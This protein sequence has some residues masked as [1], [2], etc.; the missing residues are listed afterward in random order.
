MPPAPAARELVRSTLTN[1]VAVF[2]KTYC[3]S[4]SQLCMCNL[5]VLGLNYVALEPCNCEWKSLL[6]LFN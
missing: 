4:A 5:H 1:K 2:S 3:V 6:A